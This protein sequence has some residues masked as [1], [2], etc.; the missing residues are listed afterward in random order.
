MED[1]I[2]CKL[3]N[4][5]FDTNI[6][7][8]DDEFTVILDAG[9]ATRG[10]ALILPKEHYANIYEIPEDLL[11]RA[12]ILAKK[13]VTALTDKLHTDGYNIVQN[14]GETA[15]QSD[16]NLEQLEF[17]LVPKGEV[18]PPANESQ[19]VSTTAHAKQRWVIERWPSNWPKPAYRF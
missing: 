3:A 11:G 1:C 12:A 17:S 4:H 13:V 16:R 15:G 7:Y 9:P 10:H 5:V 14:N 18:A 6:I 19:I 2:F 8:E